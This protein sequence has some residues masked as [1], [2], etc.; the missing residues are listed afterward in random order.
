[1]L[2]DTSIAKTMSTPSLLIDFNS[3]PIFGLA[4]AKHKN[5][6]IND[7]NMS[8]RLSLKFDLLG[9]YMVQQFFV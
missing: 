1:M 3:V 4:R 9:T 6:I 2:L 5:N 7:S 8:F